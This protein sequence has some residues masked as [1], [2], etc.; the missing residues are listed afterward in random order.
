MWKAPSIT[1]WL[2][3]QALRIRINALHTVKRAYMIASHFKPSASK[4]NK[5][6]RFYPTAAGANKT[7]YCHICYQHDGSLVQANQAHM[8]GSCKHDDLQSMYISRHNRALLMIQKTFHNHSTLNTAANGSTINHFTIMDASAEHSLPLGV[9][10]KIA[11]N[12]ILNVDLSATAQ[13]NLPKT[14][15]ISWPDLLIFENLPAKEAHHFDIL[16]PDAL[17]R[18]LTRYKPIV[19][20]HVIELT[21]TSNYSEAVKRKQ[22]QHRSFVRLLLDQGWNVSLAT[23][24]PPLPGSPSSPAAD[25]AP[26]APH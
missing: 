26:N 11:P 21:Y 23:P 14:Q 17:Q 7:P 4:P 6:P 12:W 20:V 22:L 2:I 3:R 9:S 19:K 13:K 1:P 15:K 16:L 8:L 24:N 18:E 5:R 25:P 10:C